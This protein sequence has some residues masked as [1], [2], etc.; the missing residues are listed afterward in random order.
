MLPEKSQK[1]LTITSTKVKNPELKK[2]VFSVY[3]KSKYKAIF[4][5]KKSLS[6]T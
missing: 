1:I 2:N 5:F 3:K 4:M 6:T